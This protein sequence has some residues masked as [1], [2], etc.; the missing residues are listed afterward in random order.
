MADKYGL[1]HK[2]ARILASV[3]F[4]EVQT[5]FADS[6]RRTAATADV[7]D[8]VECLAPQVIIA[9]SLGSVVAYEALW[10]HPHPPVQLLLT[11]GSPLAM[12]GIVLDRLREHKEPRGRPPGVVKWINIADPGDFIAV[13]KGGISANFQHVAADLTDAIGAFS[14]HQV[15][16]YLRC[17]AVASILRRPIFHRTLTDYDTHTASS[18]GR[19]LHA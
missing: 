18:D 13:P 14:F 4:R 6:D 3:F 19:D 5:Y 9:H 16:R 7:A 8:A 15:T 2:P 11:V 12:P 10:E 17:G 1:E